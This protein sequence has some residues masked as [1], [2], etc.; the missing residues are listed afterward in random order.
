MSMTGAA[1]ENAAITDILAKGGASAVALCGYITPK[2]RD[3]HLTLALSLRHLGTT[4]EIDERDISHIADLPE[5]FAPFGAK[6][7]WVKFD[8][9]VAMSVIRTAN[10]I[11]ARVPSVQSNPQTSNALPSQSPDDTFLTE[12]RLRMRVPT[13]VMEA[14]GPHCPCS[15]C[16]S[17]CSICTC[18]L[19]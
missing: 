16:H 6:I 13:T 3:G 11:A 5:S 17:D 18:L 4:L 15:T 7:V 14:S 8:A 1:V 2:K 10:S 9:L 12:G 19:P